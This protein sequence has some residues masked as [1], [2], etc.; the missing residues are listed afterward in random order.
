M[1]VNLNNE[2]PNNITCTITGQ[3]A[4]AFAYLCVYR[5]A[6]LEELRKFG[7]T[8]PATTIWKLK[9]RG[10]LEIGWKYSHYKRDP[11]TNEYVFIPYKYTM[12]WD[13]LG[14]GKDNDK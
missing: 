11:V 14:G 4:K 10:F 9:N 13:Y 12:N 2:G 5:E 3:Q 6:T 1:I 7:V 8:D